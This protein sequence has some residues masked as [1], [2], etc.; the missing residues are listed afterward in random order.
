M[1]PCRFWRLLFVLPLLGSC[2]LI[3]DYTFRSHEGP[4]LPP[5][6]SYEYTHMGPKEVEATLNRLMRYQ[7]ALDQ[8]I[9]SVSETILDKDYVTSA[10]RAQFCKAS[11]YIHEIELPPKPKI[12]D[13]G[14]DTDDAIILKLV[15]YIKRLTE[16]ITG[17]NRQVEHLKKE[18]DRLCL[19]KMP[20]R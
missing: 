7:R 4:P 6:I 20:H 2:T 8:Y 13:D 12:K 1:P 3:S 11:L 16:K 9:E 17:H 19:S 15:N 14:R 10:D 18:Y 5:R